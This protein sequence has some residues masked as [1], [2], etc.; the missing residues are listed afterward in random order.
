MVES[1]QERA[2]RNKYRRKKAMLKK[3]HK[4]AGIAFLCVMAALAVLAGRIAWINYNHGDAYSKAVLDHQ[5]YTSTTIPYKRGQILTSNGNIL[6]YSERVYNLILDPK[7]VLSDEKYKEPTLNA[8]VQCFGLNRQELEQTLAVK[9]DSQYERLAMGLTSDEIADFKA[10]VADTKNNPN[11]KGVW[12]ENSYVRKYPFSTMAC[13]VVGFASAANGGEL[14]L[15]SYYD[16]ELSGTDGV[17][18]SYVNDNLDVQETTKDAVDG[19]NIVTT[20]DYNVQRI[21]EKHI[22]AYNEEK[23]S[24]ATAVLVMNPNNGEVLGMA[25]Y[26]YFDLN[27]PRSLESSYS[28]EQLATMSD[29]DMTN[30]LYK[31]WR[32]YCISETFEPGSTFK[33]FTVASGLEEGVTYDGDVF[34][35]NGYEE[36]GGYTIRCHVYNKTGK[37]GDITLEQALMQSCNPAM[38]DIAARLGGVKFAQYQRLFG[39]GSKTGIDLPSEENGIIKKSDMSETDVA[40]NAFGQNY[41]CTMVQ[42]VSGFA[43]LI[44]GGTYYQPHLVT[45]ITDS[46]GNTISTVEPKAVKQTIS[47]STSDKIRDY[48]QSV[49]KEGTGNTAKVDGYSMGGK[50]GTAQKFP[51]GNGKYLVSFMGFAPYDNPQVLIYVVVNEPNVADQPH[52]VFAQNIAREILEEVLPYMNIYPDEKKTGVNKGY[53]VTGSKDSSQYTGKHN[54]TKSRNEKKKKN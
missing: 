52:S 19:N 5:T 18:Y 2:K 41:N 34:Y 14:G 50:T 48:L 12:F 26:P 28:Q 42:M 22:A 31:I 38:M 45:K 20:I 3:V 24:S 21:I 44:N 35:C 17:S 51:R 13:D 10:L 9:K 23:P 37:H 11:I 15:E 39:F 1:S 32:N 27:N 47:Q 54:G 53:D 33:P 4:K 36:I 46:T 16:D 25:S 8:L 7:L 30:S 29:E 6:A 40:T 43:S 49:V